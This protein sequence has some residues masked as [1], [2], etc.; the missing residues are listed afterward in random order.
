VSV[1]MV[2]VGPAAV[3][4]LCCN[5]AGN[6]GELAGAALD[7]IDDPVALVDDR[8]VSVEALWRTVLS[9]RARG[10]AERAI[11]VH[12]SWWAPTRIGVIAAAAEVLADDVVLRPRTWLLARAF[13]SQCQDAMPVVVE[14]V[15]CFVAV[16]GATVVAHSRAGQSRDVAEAVVRSVLEISTGIS[17]A[18]AIDAP[19]AVSGARTLAMMISQSLRDHHGI[20][21]VHVDDSS[22][23]SLAVEILRGEG[24]TPESHQTEPPGP[25]CRPRRGP[26]LLSA[27]LI[28]AMLGVLG[29]LRM[30]QPVAPSDDRVATTLLVEGNVAVEVPAQWPMQRI[31][32]GPGSARIQVRSP[33]DPEVALHVTQ[34]RLAIATL[35]ATA[36]ALKQA[37]DAEPSG[38]FVDF[39]PAGTS[40][41]RP[42][43]TYREIRPGHDVHWIVLVDKLIRI[44]I[45]CQNRPGHEDA[46]YS[47]CERAV[48]SAHAVG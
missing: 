17:A 35:T 12:P 13:A 34:S 24:D 22:L 6:D 40:V 7:S 10:R 1:H 46:V 9:S 31:V 21:A 2:E 11:V 39:N 18:V 36:E 28:A 16:S 20:S 25:G 14:I 43:V 29:M 37:I 45:G 3:R 26:V 44:S 41:G 38:V 15:E 23:K 27:L 30:G 4:H 5:A 19:S 8:P 48:R 33:A 42:A 32:Y 47:A